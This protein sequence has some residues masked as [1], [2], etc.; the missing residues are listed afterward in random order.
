MSKARTVSMVLMGTVLLGGCGMTRAVERAPVPVAS[1]QPQPMQ[2]LS[3]KKGSI[4]QS[5]DRNTLFID[6]KARNIGDIV[7]VLIYEQS[8]ADN[9]AKTTLERQGDTSFALGGMFDVST[10]LK[11]PEL[12]NGSI[13]LTNDHDGSGKTHRDAYIKTEISC[14]VTE[15]LSNGNLRIEG[16]RDL[17]INNENQFI[18]LSG[19]IRPEDVTSSNT[20]QSR[21]IADARIDYSGDGDIDDQ[22]RPGWLNKMMSSL[23]VF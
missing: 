23:R 6:S 5:S 10:A 20:V 15:V 17:T 21:Q 18:I 13:E 14:I 4:W 2:M 7:T 22:Q 19:L 9:N 16:R 3:P 12:A 8:T 1:L 11:T